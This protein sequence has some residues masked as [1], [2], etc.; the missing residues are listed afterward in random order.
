MSALRVLQRL[1]LLL[2]PFVRARRARWRRSKAE[3]LRALQDRGESF[4]S[5]MFR[6][7]VASDI[8]KLA[9]LHVKT[10]AMT[11]PGVKRPPTFAIREW[12]W[13]EA[14]EKNDGSWFCVV[15]ERPDKEL[16]GFAKGVVQE[17]GRGDLNKIY[18]LWEYH[19]L[20]LGHRLVGHVV[21]RF[22]N[23]GVTTMT[24]NADA[25]NPSCAFYEAIGGQVLRDDRGRP[26]PGN[27]VWRDLPKLAA[28]CPMEAVASPDVI[29]SGRGAPGR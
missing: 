27:Y 9:A 21:R 7:A 6:D 29:L 8:P 19:R 2:V 5:F 12:Q 23:T 11:Y 14:F 22:I 13:R 18:L 3:N 26:Q 16:I 15:I 24:L 20:G 25:A 4:A 10:W 1:E 17:H 28:I